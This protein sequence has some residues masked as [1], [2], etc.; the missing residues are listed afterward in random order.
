MIKKKMM[1]I[2]LAEDQT[3]LDFMMVLDENTFDMIVSKIEESCAFGSAS[4]KEV[5]T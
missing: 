1:N 2:N 4:N 3:L 5:C